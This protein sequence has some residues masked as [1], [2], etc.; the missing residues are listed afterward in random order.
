M[1]E[2][3]CGTRCALLR[4]MK[5][6]TSALFASVLAIVAGSVAGCDDTTDCPAAVS[7]GGSCT[8]AG[9]SCFAGAMQCT[10]TNGTR[11]CKTPDMSVPHLAMHDMRPPID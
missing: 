11:A 7:A 3:T 1:R 5:T 2:T 9:L 10:C 8:T 4:P 6:I